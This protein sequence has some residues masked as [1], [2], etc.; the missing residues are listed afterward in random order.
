M[1][2]AAELSAELEE[3]Q[4]SQQELW[5]ALR[6]EE[7]P[8]VRM[9]L[10]SRFSENR[11]SIVRL[12]KALGLDSAQSQSP[13][14]SPAPFGGEAA[15]VSRSAAPSTPVSSRAPAPVS[16][17]QRPGSDQT[18]GPD[19][20]STADWVDDPD[21]ADRERSDRRELPHPWGAISRGQILDGETEG[22]DPDRPLPT[23]PD[24]LG[25]ANSLPAEPEAPVEATQPAQVSR[26]AEL[27]RSVN[28]S[29]QPGPNGQPGPPFWLA[30]AGQ[31]EP[32]APTYGESESMA[33]DEPSFSEWG[34][35]IQRPD[36]T[37]PAP[38]PAPG[39]NRFEPEPDDSHL[40]PGLSSGPARDPARRSPLGENEFS[41][42]AYRDL[43][44]GEPDHGGPVANE[45]AS[46]QVPYGGPASSA[47]VPGGGGYRASG[48]GAHP[49]PPG[50]GPARSMG[51]GRGWPWS[52]WPV[53]AET[54][55][56]TLLA[57]VGGLAVA[58][59][60][61]GWLAL[62]RPFM[63]D[64]QANVAGGLATESTEVAGPVVDSPVDA[65]AA[66]LGGLGLGHLVVDERDG[67]IYLSG[68][69]DNPAELSA[70]VGASEALA[71][72]RT[73][74]A[75][76]LVVVA[77]V[78]PVAATS[79]EEAAPVQADAYQS[80]LDRIL[81]GTPIIFEVGQ[82]RMTD[83]H[84][85]IL[86]NVAAI[87]VMYPELP[88]TIVGF[89][90]DSGTDEENRRLSLAR[91]EAVRVY[92]VSQGVAEGML[93][94]EPRGEET[95]TGSQALA[96]LERRIEFEVVAPATTTLP[97]GGE[98]M[99]VAI[100]APSARNDLAFTQSMV[101]AVNVIAAERGSVEVTITDSTFVPD[102]AAAAIRRY[103]SEGYDLVIAHGSQFGGPLLEIAPD[104]PEVTFAWG[105]ASDTFGLDNVYAYDAAAG[106]GG[107]VMGAMAARLSASGVVGVVGPIEVG[108]AELYVNGF[109][110]GAKAES[111][112]TNVRVA[113]TGSFSDLTLAAETAQG[114]IDAGADVMTGSAQM[115]VGAVSTASE[116][117]ALWF[118][119][120]SNQSSLAPD[121]VVASQ[122]YHWEVIFR[123][124]VTDI[125]AGTPQGQTYSAN[126]ANGGL[127]VEFNPDYPLPPEVR[128]RA[129]EI[130]AGIVGGSIRVP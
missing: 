5:A 61:I 30:T 3:L 107:Y 42:Q 41:D 24:L 76:G 25:Q 113:Y 58:V 117:G 97:A 31:V 85:R 20:A 89:T 37:A 116:H 109:S 11:A 78:E 40:V 108:D 77:P 121:L 18:I 60:A 16:R 126:L 38:A 96:S 54:S 35:A 57:V 100:V 91:A 86:D 45:P 80:E 46:G 17:P 53:L 101:D 87:M 83:L 88:V 122:V 15:M 22:G 70:A 12:S 66:V 67:V 95:A 6:S 74:N 65:I 43:T 32:P 2:S 47:A 93:G 81:A 62:A 92:L 98:V 112:A 21:P 102:E 79:N 48:P 99:R 36:H 27:I 39:L 130:V 82:T 8:D 90:D 28:P 119:T 104:F 52:Q 68:A 120:Q 10:L 106:E 29:G 129:D 94:I 7:D 4:R 84:L 127:V 13:S 103:A 111:A 64:D 128:Q 71:A 123:Q 118:G 14:Q 33:T 1:S 23:T 115:V 105:T 44:Y 124:I 49:Y 19:S 114:H 63:G 73:V 51:P 75:S 55:P 26:L 34:P 110:A 69:V 125:D 56:A 9:S 72:G 50:P 59:I